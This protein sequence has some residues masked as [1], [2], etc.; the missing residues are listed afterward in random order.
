[1]KLHKM[2]VQKQHGTL[3]CD[4]VAIAFALEVCLGSNVEDVSFKQWCSYTRAHTALGAA[5]IASY[6][7]FC[8]GRSLDVRLPPNTHT[9]FYCL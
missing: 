8:M 6:P 3:D 2:S 7:L 5:P 4:L 1:M 9:P